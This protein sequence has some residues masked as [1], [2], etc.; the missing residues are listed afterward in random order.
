MQL[1]L[2]QQSAEHMQLALQWPI[3]KSNQKWRTWGKGLYT[4]CKAQTDDVD[5]GNIK[6][7]FINRNHSDMHFEGLQIWTI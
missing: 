1:Y 4:K 7:L 5:Y 3:A 2:Q 6:F